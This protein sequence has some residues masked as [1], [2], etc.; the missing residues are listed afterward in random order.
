MYSI[1]SIIYLEKKEENPKYEV[2][3]NGGEGGNHTSYVLLIG[4]NLR[5]WNM[6]QIHTL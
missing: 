3:S 1:F 5:K 6:G 2:Q 4:Y